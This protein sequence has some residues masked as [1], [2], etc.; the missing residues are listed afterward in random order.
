MLD[1]DLAEL[2]HVP[3]KAFN[4]AVR[5]NPDRFLDDFM[6]QL[7]AEEAAAMRSQIVTVWRR[8]IRYRPYVFT[9][10][11]M[12]MLSSVLDSK[13]AVQMKIVIMRAFVRLREL[14]ATH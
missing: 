9:E 11:G 3:P 14:M 1:S 13:G 5:R 7:T 10:L 6:F 8:N 12:A 4:Q 2:Y